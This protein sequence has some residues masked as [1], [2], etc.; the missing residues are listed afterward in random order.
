M[1]ASILIFNECAKG[2]ER[3]GLV[4]EVIRL[5]ALVLLV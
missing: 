5:A 4:F 2:S 1:Q 3:R